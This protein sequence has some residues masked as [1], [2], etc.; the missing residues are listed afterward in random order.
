[1]PIPTAKMKK[2][3]SISCGKLEPAQIIGGGCVWFFFATVLLENANTR[4]TDF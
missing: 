2:R 3:V 4:K 1:M